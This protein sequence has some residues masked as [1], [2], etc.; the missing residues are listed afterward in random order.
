MREKILLLDDRIIEKPVSWYIGNKIRY[1]NFASVQLFKNK[2]KIYVRNKKINDYKKIFRKV[3]TS[4]GWGKTPL[5]WTD[6]S[7]NNE[8]SYVME[9]IKESYEA[10]PDK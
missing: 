10:A 6:I 7:N 4:Y 2:I 8:V 9:I 1:F 3:P 5:W